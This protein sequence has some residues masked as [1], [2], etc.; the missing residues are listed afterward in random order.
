MVVLFVLGAWPETAAAQRRGAAR[1]RIVV[2][3][4]VY[5]PIYV[6]PWYGYGYGY[7]GRYRY[8]WHQFGYP[9]P[10]FGY[11][12]RYDDLTTS[13]RL[14]VTPRETEVFVNGYHAGTVDDFD[15][16][17]QRLRLRPGEHEI[18]LYLDGYRTL[19]Q[20]LYL[21]ARGDQKIRHTMVPLQAG[22]AQEPRPEPQEMEPADQ[23]PI[24]PRA[25]GPGPGGPGRGDLPP[26]PL[27]PPGVGQAA[28]YGAVSIRVQPADAEVLIDGEPWSGP[29]NPAGP[30]GNDR[31]VVQL[32]GG[33]HRVEIRRDGYDPYVSDVDVR[34]GETVPLN[35]SLLRR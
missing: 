14:E 35:V 23:P 30:T 19:A 34:A 10:P 29:A 8:P 1:A 16:I 7:G 22:E 15:G 6:N 9:Y 4:G 31:L 28:Q 2:G 20:Q 25:G 13:L 18:V 26:R 21:N 32:P 5:R 17:F 12:G 3:A 33:R 11:Y 24:P 27:P